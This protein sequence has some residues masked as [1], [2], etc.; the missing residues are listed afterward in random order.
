MSLFSELQRRNVI[1]VAIAYVAFAWLIIQFVE[2]LFPV[3]GL[4]AAAIRIVVALLAIGLPLVLVFSW[5]YELTPEGLKLD[6]DVDRSRSIAGRTGTKLDRLIIAVLTLAVGFFAVDKF[7]L[8]PARD[9]EREAAVRDQA[10]SDALIEAYGENSIAVLPFENMS[11]DPNDEYFSDGISEE[12]LNLLSRIPELRVISRSSSFALKDK[13]FTAPEIAE[14]LNVALVLEGSVRRF[15]DDLR[16]T[17]QLI[18]AR[19][20]THL[21]S[22]TYDRKMENLFEIQDE[23]SAA[24]VDALRNQLDVEVS[25]APQATVAANRET[26]D[27]YL[28]GRHLIAERN[29]DSD[30]QAVR[31]FERAVSLDPD[32]APAHAELAVTIGRNVLGDRLSRENKLKKL[33]YHVNKAMELDPALPEAHAARGWMLREFDKPG[34]A[35]AAFRRAIELNPN[36]AQAYVWL[37]ED[38][39]DPDDNL[40]NQETALRLDPLSRPAN[41]NYIDALIARNRLD[42]AERRI[43]KLATFEPAGAILT[44][45]KLEALGGNWSASALA[46]LQAANNERD[47]LVYGGFYARDFRWTLAA[48]GLWEE[49]MRLHPDFPQVLEAFF[50]S[51]E[52]AVELAEARLREDGIEFNAGMVLAHV[53]QFDRARP[54][55]EGNWAVSRQSEPASAIGGDRMYEARFAEALVAMRRKAGDEPGA[56]EVIEALAANARRL[57]D[58]GITMTSRDNSVDYHAGI[59]AYLSGDRAKGLALIAKAVD[60]GFWIP[61]KAAFQKA[62]F[63]DPGFAPIL[64]A[65]E[66][67]EARE[68]ARILDVVCND[69]PYAAVWQPLPETCEAHAKAS[70]D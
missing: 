9:A 3:Y 60:D 32:F 49:A 45:G 35:E 29:A 37:A 44:R 65:N 22:E 21:W 57:R 18:E 50:G 53:G 39:V 66:A 16:I 31:E 11:A 68:R 63:E 13:V 2:A 52:K 55:L 30:R 14:Q 12:L 19:S 59:A 67:R 43:E 15:A 58:A 48:V 36:Y 8:D 4:T 23:I 70:T 28:L 17:A 38:L 5:L 7:V 27:A 69:N 6:R 40:A 26:H 24:I 34:E 47:K 42:E 64:A 61:P 10:R 33:A 25:R 1:R 20:D 56:Q 62:L 46:Y 54:L 41:F 51:P